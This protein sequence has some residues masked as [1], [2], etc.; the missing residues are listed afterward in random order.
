MEGERSGVAVD[1]IQAWQ[2]RMISDEERLESV[3]DDPN[4]EKDKGRKDQSINQSISQSIS[5]SIVTYS[6][7]GCSARARYHVAAVVAR[8][9]GRPGRVRGGGMVHA[10][11]RKRR[12]LQTLQ[13][14]L[15]TSRG[16]SRLQDGGCSELERWLLL[17]GG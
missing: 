13:S 4:D 11:G 3:R 10:R 16:G 17:L 1:L 15:T 9:H 14:W 6:L 2:V 12:L 5:S 8:V 7:Y